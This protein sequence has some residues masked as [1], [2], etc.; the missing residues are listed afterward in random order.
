MM[1]YIIICILMCSNLLHAQVPIVRGLVTDAANGEPLPGVNIIYGKD[2]GVATDVNGNFEIFGTEGKL[3]LQFRYVGYNTVLRTI[4]VVK[5]QT[6]RLDVKMREQQHMLN[7]L[8]V[9]ASRYE[10]R[11]SDVIVSM[12]VIKPSTIENAHTLNIE[13]ALQKVPGLMFL[14]GQASIRSGNGYSYGVG[15]RVLLLLDDLP[16]LTGAGGEAKWDFVPLENLGQVEVLKGAASALYGSS[17]LNGVINIRTSYPKEKPE[18][19]LVFYSGIYGQPKR[20]EIAWWGN[21]QPFYSGMRFTH[22]QMFGNLDIVAGGNIYT[23]QGYR[24]KE[25]EQYARFNLNTRYR[26]QKVKG[27]SGGINSNFMSKKG[28]NFLIWLNGTD[29]VY[30]TSPVIDQSYDNT[31]LNIDPFIIYNPNPNM[32]H[33]LKA[34]IFRVSYDND[35]MHNYDN[36]SFAEYQF[37]KQWENNLSLTAGVS[38][39]FIDANSNLFSNTKH[40][41]NNQALYFQADKRFRSWSFVLGGRY[42]LHKINE[43]RESSKP[44]LRAGFNYQAKE[45]TFIRGSFGQG[46]RYPA[47]AEK[48]AFTQVGALRI[49][50]ND[51]LMPE[52]GWNAELG[53][54]QGFSYGQTKGYLDA[55]L[56][57][58]EYKDMIEFTFGQHYPANLTNPTL[59][60]FFKYTGF[61]AYNIGHARI[62]GFEVSQNGQGSLGNLPIDFMMGYTFTDPIEKNFDPKKT[63]ASTDKN[64]LKYRFYHSAKASIN[65][66]Y[67]KLSMGM[68]LDYHSYIINIDMAFEDSLRFPPPS[69]LAYAVILP[70]MKEYRA[71]NNTGDIIFNWR[72]AWDP[73][74][75]TRLSFIINNLFNRE[76]MTRPGDVQPP[77]VYA[78]QLSMK[79]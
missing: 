30:R 8:V 55:A 66:S 49:F 20:S 46:F 7:E 21:T 50:P 45:F 37:L 67:R 19:N 27:L 44:L 78:L 9:S 25:H 76:Y 32:R 38:T 54:K 12:D 11:L 29:G 4:D 34:R 39:T 35:T 5:G 68:H 10:Q 24:E 71:K 47:I 59:W 36:S 14:G 74:P 57:W 28:G 60:D 77:R 40:T 63:T 79:I 6:L 2:R 42:E 43:L 16:M 61:R 64:I 18:T 17:A 58:S 22:S 70:G 26:S 23:D 51:T 41:A 75:G 73:L 72:I 31:R 69:N 13:T 3:H 48:F 1:R 62:A 65:V 33:S 56:F 15:S 52:R 53:M